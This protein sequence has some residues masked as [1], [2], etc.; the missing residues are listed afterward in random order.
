MR[1]SFLALL[2]GLMVGVG[3]FVSFENLNILY[4]VGSGLV[5]GLIFY[6]RRSRAIF[7][8]LGLVL[9]FS[10]SSLRFSSKALYK[11]ESRKM[12]FT[13]V[14][15]RESQDGFRYFLE[16]SD[17]EIR[18]KTL[19]FSDEDLHI[20]DKFVARAD[21]KKPNTNTNPNL[22]SYRR[23]LASKDIFSEAMID[24]DFKVYPS[25]NFFLRIKDS[26]YGCIHRIF[27]SNLSK[28]VA[29]FVVSV[30]LGEN[31]V[32]G[33]EIRDLGLAHILAVSGLHLDILMGFL[34]FIFT[35]M[36]I[37][38]KYAYGIGFFLSLAYG[39][40]ISFPFSVMRVIGL[41]LIGFLAFLYKK[42]FDRVKALLIIASAILVANPFALLNSGF[43]LSFVASLSVYLIYPYFKRRFGKT[44][45]GD[46]LA[47]TTAIQVGLFPFII[48]YYGS[49]NLISILAN[50]L[51]VP[52]FT[53]AMYMIFA[54]VMGIFIIKPLGLLVLVIL[55]ILVEGILSLTIL[56]GSIRFTRIDFAKPSILLVIYFFV[57]IL[58]IINLGVSRAKRHGYIILASL[59][60]L[61][62]GS[63]SDTNKTFYQ[64]IDIGQGDAFL[65]ADRGDYYLI[66]VGGPKYK[67]YDSGEAIL[68]PYLKSLGIGKI[69][70]IFISHEDSD[71]IGNLKGVLDN[72]EVENIFVTNSNYKSVKDHDP[73]LLKKGDK[74][75]LKD[76]EIKVIAEGDSD[77]EN[78]DSM[79]LLIDIRGIK[80]MSMGD[81]PAELEKNIDEKADILKLSH[82]GSATSSQ[83]DFIERVD[84]RIVLISAGRNNLYGHPAREIMDNVADRIIYNTQIDG[85]VEMS[86]D[87]EF[88]IEGYVKGGYF[89]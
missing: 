64:M 31:L 80:I 82:H 23:Y 81:M 36:G 2:L 70:G 26:F 1:R 44:Y 53:F 72:F 77:D 20:G 24:G 62:V 76:T 34:L 89:R 16:A 32:D 18:E 39:Y 84:P 51:V 28:P 42:P 68:I 40:L 69:K 21:F 27:D 5:L 65:L 58:V 74:I 8:I 37:S 12:F 86:F 56:L 85:L 66:D 38:Y 14:Q 13:V 88:S 47:F 60:L 55:N 19:Y 11:D 73:T 6:L 87:G 4:V 29:N 49:I 41:N 50:F 48:Y 52:I 45:V 46:S 78:A 59:V 79:G 63:L 22:F 71:H 9:S 75:V 7:C 15:K 30:V 3:I 54:L 57:L 25:S 17:G 35:R 33:D 83:R 67:S 10:L 43:V 61:L